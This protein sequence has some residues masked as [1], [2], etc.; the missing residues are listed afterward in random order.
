[1]RQPIPRFSRE[2][3]KCLYMNTTNAKYK[4]AHEHTF[5]SGPR[6]TLNFSSLHFFSTVSLRLESS[7]FFFCRPFCFPYK[8]PL[9]VMWRVERNVI[10]LPQ[11]SLGEGQGEW[12]NAQKP[13]SPELNHVSVCNIN[14]N[15]L[16]CETFDTAHVAIAIKCIYS[17]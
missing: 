16:S 2:T 4:T 15:N 1:M 7:A 11:I 3:V 6:L 8:Q 12:P 17:H 9:V 14:Y 5:W 13:S 10:L